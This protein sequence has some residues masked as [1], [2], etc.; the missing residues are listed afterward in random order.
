M[1][2]E[3]PSALS[4]SGR[5]RRLDRSGRIR[6]GARRRRC[7]R[8]ADADTDELERDGKTECL[9]TGWFKRTV[10]S[11]PGFPSPIVH[12]PSVVYE[13]KE[14]EHGKLVL[15]KK[16]GKRW[17]NKAYLLGDKKGVSA[18]MAYVRE[19]GRMRWGRREDEEDGRP[20]D[21]GDKDDEDGD[22]DRDGR[23]KDGGEEGGDSE[24]EVERLVD[25]QEQDGDAGGR[26][27]T[28]ME[29][30]L[31]WFGM[32]IGGGRRNDETQRE[33]DAATRAD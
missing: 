20:E 7:R 24:D 27:G 18:L 22:E 2:T 5:D 32:H 13:V 19:T 9:C 3:G 16:A 14:S 17:A 8:D 10:L 31:A 11:T 1:R 23:R 28:D 15:R 12:P 30:F 21:R 33:R 4:P 29:R 26:R 6:Q 25:E